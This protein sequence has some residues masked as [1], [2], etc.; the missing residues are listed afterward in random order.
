MATPGQALR[1]IIHPLVRFATLGV[2]LPQ[3]ACVPLRFNA[4]VAL[5]CCSTLV[6]VSCRQSTWKDVSSNKSRTL[7]PFFRQVLMLHEWMRTPSGG[8]ETFWRVQLVIISSCHWILICAES[9]CFCSWLMEDITGAEI[10]LA[11]RFAPPFS[12]SWVLFWHFP[13]S[14]RDTQKDLGCPLLRWWR[15]WVIMIA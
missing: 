14:H 8:E 6:A 1:F 13:G 7:V 2:G 9:C 10:A 4:I 11:L 15:D 3:T 5:R 12:N